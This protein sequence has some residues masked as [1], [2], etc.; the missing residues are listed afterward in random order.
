MGAVPDSDITA[1]VTFLPKGRSVRAGPIVGRS[2]G[3]SI[4]IDGTLYEVRFDLQP[5]KTIEL[6]S[7]AV[8]EGMFEDPASVLAVLAVGKTFT[9][10]DR[11]AIGHGVVLKVSGDA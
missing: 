11:G 7:T 2:L 3:C 6:G 1:E 10:W 4:V 9:L 5:G 8:L